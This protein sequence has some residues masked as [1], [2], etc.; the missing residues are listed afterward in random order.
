MKTFLALV[1]FTLIGTCMLAQNNIQ[2]VVYLKNGS[3]IRGV[4]MELVPNASIKIE[5]SDRSIFVYRMDEIEKI[6]KEVK[7]VVRK[8]VS[9]PVHQGEGLQ[10]GYRGIVD[11]GYQLG[12]GDFGMDRF[13]MNIINGGQVSPYFFIG[14]GMGLRYYFDED[15]ALIPLFVHARANILD[16]KISPYFALSIGYTLNASHD[17]EPVGLLLSP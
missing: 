7:P 14:G 17:L 5:T 2:D 3:I 9:G 1:V 16:K 4:I 10:S 13:K 12:L 6:T 8:V 15:T 11:F